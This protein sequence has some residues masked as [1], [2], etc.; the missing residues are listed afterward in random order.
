M[1][2]LWVAL[3]VVLAAGATGYLWV[4]GRDVWRKG[5][6]L[7]AEL[8]E[9]SARLNEVAAPLQDAADEL[10]ETRAEL[11]VFADPTELR[12]DRRKAAKRKGG[13]KP[14]RQPGGRHR[15]DPSPTRFGASSQGSGGRA[16]ERTT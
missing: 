8:A 15:S 10:E 16:G 6:A 1:I 14:A 2:W 7:A 13:V 3:W 9:A 11:A 12:R 4:L 5:K